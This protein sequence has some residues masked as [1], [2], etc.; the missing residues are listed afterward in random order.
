MCRE[1]YNWWVGTKGKR[2]TGLMFASAGANDLNAFYARFDC[3]DC[4]QIR[5]KLIDGLAD[6]DTP[7][8]ERLET[9]LTFLSMF[10]SR[11]GFFSRGLTMALF[12]HFG[13]VPADSDT[14][15]TFIRT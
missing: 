3:H 12:R 9:G 15:M 8:G 14:F 5:F 2:G 13:T 10:G 6:S 1:G 11:E 4:G 7:V